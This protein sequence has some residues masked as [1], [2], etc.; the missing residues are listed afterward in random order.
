MNRRLV[1]PLGASLLGILASLIGGQPCL[2]DGPVVAVPGDADGNGRVDEMDVHT[3]ER[4]LADKRFK[5]PK[6]RNADVTQ[7]NQIDPEDNEVI[8]MRVRGEP[9]L[10]VRA[11]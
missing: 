10:V 9:T 3:I 1:A 2:A 6:L 8:A 7:N 11:I 5:T 4:A